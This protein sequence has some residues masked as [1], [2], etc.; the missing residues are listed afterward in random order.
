M[1]AAVSVILLF[2]LLFQNCRRV[3]GITII[4]P[5][6]TAVFHNG[7]Y[8]SF[9]IKPNIMENPIYEYIV[10]I[11]HRDNNGYAATR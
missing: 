11:L 7:R 8:A 10:V 9:E 2:I 4:Y 5:T 6:A 3:C 1:Q